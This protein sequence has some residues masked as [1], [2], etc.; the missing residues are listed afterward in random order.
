M[1][2]TVRSGAHYN[3]GGGSVLTAALTALFVACSGGLEPS[4]PGPKMAAPT[5]S[6]AAAPVAPATEMASGPSTPAAIAPQTAALATPEMAPPYQGVP[7]RWTLDGKSSF[8]SLITTKQTNIAEVHTFERFAASVDENGTATLLIDLA[9]ISTNVDLRDQRVRDFLFEVASF[10]EATVSF[11]VDVA[12]VEG[13]AV[14][15]SGEL[16][17][18]A[19]LT[20]HGTTKMVDTSLWLTRLTE[21]DIVVQTKKPIVLNAL[22]FNLGAG[23]ETLIGLAG[24]E[25]ISAAVPVEFMLTL[26]TAELVAAPVPEA[27]T[28]APAP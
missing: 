17:V 9:S 23:I 1:R 2:R 6:P 25:S 7:L 5:S 11:T 12:S 10:P 20:L 14:G 26:K 16:P 8:L 27:V 3:A 28:A 24:L 19:S 15:S 18:S 13:V 22:D 4:E 21:S